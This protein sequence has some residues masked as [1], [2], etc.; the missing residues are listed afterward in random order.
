MTKPT[1]ADIALNPS[2]MDDYDPNSM[3][4]DQAR[5]FIKQFLS[6]VTATETL[7]L[8]ETLGRVLASAI[9][10]PC[11]VPNY[12]NSAMD[13]YAYHADSL[14]LNSTQTK[15]KLIGAAFAGNAFDGKVGLNECVRIMT[16]AVMPEGADTVIMQERVTVDGDMISINELQK[17]GANVRYAGEDLKHNQVVLDKGHLMRP[18]DLGLIA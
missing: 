9:L 8:R 6:P 15:L 14:A 10:S 11:N 16:G 3:P 13:G 12:D 17:R 2:C 1:L 18:S 5:I 4:V 7:N